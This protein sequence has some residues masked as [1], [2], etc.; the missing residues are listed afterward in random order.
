[1]IG[2]GIILS[3]ALR[4][5]LLAQN[6]DAPGSFSDRT[7]LGTD[8]YLN[9]FWSGCSKLSPGVNSTILERIMVFSHLRLGN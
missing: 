9:V 2:P 1:M 4:C 3:G 7:V 5:V 8:F 6:E